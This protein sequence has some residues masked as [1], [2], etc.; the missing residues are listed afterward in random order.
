VLR[1]EASGATTT[2]A[3]LHVFH[4]NGSGMFLRGTAQ[5][6][7]CEIDDNTNQGINTAGGGS[8]RV[9]RCNVHDNTG[10]GIHGQGEFHIDNTFVTGN[11][12]PGVLLGQ[13]TGAGDTETVTFSTIANNGTT[14]T[15]SAIDC[16]NSAVTVDSSIIASNGAAPQVAIQCQVTYTLFSDSTPTASPTNIINADPKF[17]DPINDFHLQDQSPAIDKAN[18]AATVNTDFDGDRRPKGAGFDIGAD[19]H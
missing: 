18:P 17:V 8:T 5:I 12:A 19:E 11:G 3:Y 9:A 7:R 16:R 10:T 1:V 13:N 15:T 6:L 4:G 14:G 2:A